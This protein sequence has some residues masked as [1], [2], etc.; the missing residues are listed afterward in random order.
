MPPNDEE[1]HKTSFAQIANIRRGPIVDEVKEYENT[2]YSQINE[3]IS[4]DKSVKYNVYAVVTNLKRLPSQ[5]RGSKLMS[6][7]YVADP[8]CMGTYGHPDFQ[9]R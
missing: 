3:C 5:T 8:T 1:V 9:F 4:I 6:Q 7:V 2:I